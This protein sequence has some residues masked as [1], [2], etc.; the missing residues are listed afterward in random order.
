MEIGG[1]IKQLRYKAGWTQEQLAERLSLS[2]QSVSKWETG[3]SMPD[4]TLL[5]LL[6]EAFGVSIDELFDLTR[7]EKLLRIENRLDREEEL[8]SGAFRDCEDFLREQLDGAADRQRALSLLARLYH[9]RM[10]ADACRVS[11]CAREAIEAAPE[12]KDCQWL[13]QMAEGAAPWDWNIANHAKVID[14]YKGL[15][16][17][18]KTEPR[19]P[20]PYCYLLD[21]LIADHRTAEAEK[22]LRAYE[23]LPAHKPFMAAVY[24]AHIELAK[25]DEAKADAV[26]EEAVKQY[27]PDSGVLF[28]AAQYYAGKCEYEK[29]VSYYEASYAAEE[30]EKPRFTDALQGIAMIYEIMGDY[31][32]AAAAC[33]RILENLRDEWGFGDEDAPVQEAEREKNRLLQ[34][35]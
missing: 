28:E 11:R 12:K 5:P 2:A 1:K 22:T 19:S 33:G 21:Q 32:K 30:N 31:K 17:K 25:Y 7:E 6:A 15:I 20:L 4:I 29:A 26:M 8:D 3:V 35:A 24:R 18:D 13:L 27:A 34:K 10:E 14:F 16:A 23:Q 9:H